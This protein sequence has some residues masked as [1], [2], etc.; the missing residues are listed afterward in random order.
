MISIHVKFTLASALFAWPLLA[1]TPRLTFFGDIRRDTT[2][3]TGPYLLSP[4]SPPKAPV[5]GQEWVFIKSPVTPTTSRAPSSGTL[6]LGSSTD[7]DLAKARQKL[8]SAK[9]RLERLEAERAA[10][11]RREQPSASA[12]KVGPRLYLTPEM[13]TL[14]ADPTR[15]ET[16]MP[17]TPRLQLQRSAP[18]APSK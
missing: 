4:A 14:P 6:V 17:A 15:F 5:E 18:P 9:A 12:P 7:S 16:Q 3:L 1:S 10:I 13:P 2:L 11:E 8:E